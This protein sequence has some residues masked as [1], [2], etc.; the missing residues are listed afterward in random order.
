MDKEKRWFEI[1]VFLLVNAVYML[2][3]KEGKKDAN[4]MLWGEI[5]RQI[6]SSIYTTGVFRQVKQM[7]IFYVLHCLLVN[8]V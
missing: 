7:L 2:I 4:I 6:Y 1:F 3:W 5:N 8:M